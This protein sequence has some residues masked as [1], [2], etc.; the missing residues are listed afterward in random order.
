[1]LKLFGEKKVS[2]IDAR[3]AIQQRKWSRAIAFY[4]KKLNGERDYPLW[5]L[6]GDLHMNNNS[7]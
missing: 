4:E 1:M 7:R 3:A 5:N 2:E 6:L